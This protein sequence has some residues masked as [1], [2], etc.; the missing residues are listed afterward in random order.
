MKGNGEPKEIISLKIYSR[1]NIF[2]KWN[3]L[4]EVEYDFIRSES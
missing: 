3:I 2:K 1:F 4:M